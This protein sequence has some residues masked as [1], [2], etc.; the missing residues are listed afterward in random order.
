MIIICVIIIKLNN[1]LFY[2]QI[3]TLRM[4]NSLNFCTQH[5]SYCWAISSCLLQNNSDNVYRQWQWPL[6]KCFFNQHQ[7]TAH[8]EYHNNYC[9]TRKKICWLNLCFNY[10]T[11]FDKKIIYVWKQGRYSLSKYYK[12]NENWQFSFSRLQLQTQREETATLCPLVNCSKE[13]TSKKKINR[14]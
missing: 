3:V 5:K 10:D 7:R 2:L 13:K 9:V 6:R 14:K 12:I 8:A 11:T 1:S 4:A